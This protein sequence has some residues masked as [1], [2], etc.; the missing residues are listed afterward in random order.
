ME[1]INLNLRPDSLLTKFSESQELVQRVALIAIPFLSLYPPTRMGVAI[2]SGAIQVI[3]LW[4]N[5]ETPEK[6][7]PKILKLSGYAFLIYLSIFRP[8]ESLAITAIVQMFSDIRAREFYDVASQMVYLYSVYSNGLE[9]II[10]SLVLQAAK[11][12]RE[13]YKE[14]KKGRYPELIAKLLMVTFRFYQAQEDLSRI[15]RRYFGKTVT[16]DAWDRLIETDDL[17]KAIREGNY[18]DTI[19]D[20]QM[21]RRHTMNFENLVFRRVDFS[22]NEASLIRIK[23]VIFHKCQMDSIFFYRVNFNQVLWNDCNLRKGT[24]YHCAGENIA[25]KGCDLTRFCMS[26][27]LFSRLVINQSTL[28]GASFLNTS[29]KDSILKSCDLV[30]VLLCGADFKKIGCTKNEIT[31]PVIALTWDFHEDGSWGSPIPD[32]LEEQGALTLKFPIYLEDIG[33]WHLKREVQGKLRSYSNYRLSRAQKL[34]DDPNKTPEIEK[35]KN[36]MAQ[37]MS[38]ADGLIL[39]GGED[40]EKEFYLDVFNGADY[41]RSLVEFA[42]IHVGKPVFGICRGCQVLNAYFGGTIKDVPLQRGVEPF[43]YNRNHRLGQLLEKRAGGAPISGYSAHSQAANQMGQNLHV[44]L[45]KRG[46]VKAFMNEEGSVMGTQ[47]HPERY[48]EEERRFD[49]RK[50]T[51]GQI[52]FRM[53]LDKVNA[54]RGGSTLQQSRSALV[55]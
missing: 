43:D 1:Q 29:L 52:F 30:N 46:I 48:L 7:Y 40:V 34:L 51:L 49:S 38:Y 21:G 44:T 15:Y 31:K 3:S 33:E 53:F 50:L 25:F 39:S 9:W 47:F 8:K 41:R 11:E 37:V 45:T 10:A 17:S 4:K 32:V 42:A 2:I 5:E 13:A 20:I 22:S 6:G 18:S 27:S 36:K 24:F 26:E 35:I 14:Y 28:Y 54:N 12:C 19:Q 16:Q 23:N 55:G